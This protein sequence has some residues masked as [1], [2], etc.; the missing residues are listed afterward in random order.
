MKILIL[1]LIV[2]TNCRT[3]THYLQTQQ[4]WKNDKVFSSES[5]TIHNSGG[6]VTSLASILHPTG[7]LIDYKPINPQNLNNFF[8]KYPQ[9]LN[10]GELNIVKFKDSFFIKQLKLKYKTT[11]NCGLLKS[12]IDNYVVIAI[13]NGSSI[14]GVVKSLD[15]D[16]I[17]IH[18]SKDLSIDSITMNQCQNI[19]VLELLQNDK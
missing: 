10:N 9:L 3:I 13:I 14:T 12:F 17:Y 16:K 11:V 8:Q 5:Q 6:L 18:H 19:I 2:V 4:D 15:G 7:V 1:A